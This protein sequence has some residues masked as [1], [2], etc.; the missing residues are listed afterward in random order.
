LTRFFEQDKL[1]PAQHCRHFP[2][3]AR[4]IG[5]M[6][7]ET[8]GFDKTGRLRPTRGNLIHPFGSEG[9]FSIEATVRLRLPEREFAKAL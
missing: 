9:N 6:R 5:W 1:E 8:A 2:A 7:M 4:E 3:I